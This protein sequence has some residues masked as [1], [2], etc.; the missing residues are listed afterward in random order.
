M[1]LELVQAEAAGA[2]WG[3]WGGCLGCRAVGL[4]LPLSSTGIQYQ[5][6]VG[7]NPI[8]LPA[9]PASRRELLLL[10]KRAECDKAML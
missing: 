10:A 6:I 1:V 8:P 2:D 7:E 5:R 4:S 3:F 9:S